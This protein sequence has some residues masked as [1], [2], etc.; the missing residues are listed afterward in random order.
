MLHTSFVCACSSNYVG[1]GMSA[2]LTGLALGCAVLVL[3]NMFL[4]EGVT[5]QLL[6]FNHSNFFV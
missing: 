4:E 2:S 3:G 1:E 5:Q 6:T